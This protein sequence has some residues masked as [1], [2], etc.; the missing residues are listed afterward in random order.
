MRQG[1]REYTGIKRRIRFERVNFGYPGATEPAL[2]D[3][4]L[5][6][7]RGETVALVGTSGAGKSTLADLVPRFYDPTDGRITVDGVDLR[8]FSMRSVRR[9]MGVVSQDTFLFNSSVRY[10][11]MYGSENK[12]EADLIDAAKRANEIGR[13]HV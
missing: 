2:N 6:I 4:S 10:N 11:L 9:A 8:D 12:T 3:I 1:D 5:D 7:E 13:A